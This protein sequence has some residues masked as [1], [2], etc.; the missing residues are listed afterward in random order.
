VGDA[1]TALVK[2]QP[3]IDPKTGKAMLRPVMQSAHRDAD[4]N[5]LKWLP[6]HQYN[7]EFGD[8]PEKTISITA[9]TNDATMQTIATRVEAY[10]KKNV[11]P[12]PTP[13]DVVAEQGGE[14]EVAIE[15]VPTGVSEE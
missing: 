14:A 11:L 4:P 10:Q 1:V 3:R 8:A 15:E 7:D 9:I 5:T 6:S 2:Y 12:M 13:S